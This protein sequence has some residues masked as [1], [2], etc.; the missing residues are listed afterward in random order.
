[1]EGVTSHSTMASTDGDCGCRFITFSW[2]FLPKSEQGK[3]SNW[4]FQ[5]FKYLG[6]SAVLPSS[7]SPIL[8][9]HLK[10]ASGVIFITLFGY[11]VY[12]GQ[13]LLGHFFS[14]QC[15]SVLLERPLDIRS[16]RRLSSVEHRVSSRV[17]GVESLADG[18][19]WLA[20]TVCFHTFSHPWFCRV[21]LAR[22]S[23]LSFPRCTSAAQTGAGVIQ[24]EVVGSAPQAHS[25][26]SALVAF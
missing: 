6:P 4:M 15:T 21:Q 2:A 24:N 12:R 5:S 8:Q 25:R 16:C 13:Q 1:M 22:K 7:P 10:R 9:Q 20:H 14:L 19:D 11:R 26:D 17:S 3:G 23:L 18:N